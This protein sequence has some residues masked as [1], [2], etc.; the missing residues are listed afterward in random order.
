MR[1]IVRVVGMI[2]PAFVVGCGVGHVEDA[3]DVTASSRQALATSQDCI[4]Q[5]KQCS[6]AAKTD[7]DRQACSAEVKACIS[8][9]IPNAPA[10]ADAGVPMGS[11]PIGGLP[12]I[13]VNLP[14]GGAGATLPPSLPADAGITG[15]GDPTGALAG[16]APCVST[17]KD[18]LGGSTPPMTCAEKVRDCIKAAL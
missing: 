18:C 5:A 4:D 12:G 10:G 16:I 13:P 17:L 14:D 9:I 2:V 3:P 6:A 15:I 7:D 11:L 1:N 8:T